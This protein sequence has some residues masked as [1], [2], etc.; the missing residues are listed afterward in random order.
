VLRKPCV[1]VF[2]IV[3]G[4]CK[5]LDIIASF[6][7]ISYLFWFSTSLCRSVLKRGHD[8]PGKWDISIAF[9][10][11]QLKSMI[12]QSIL[13]QLKQMIYVFDVVLS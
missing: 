10:V 13:G 7:G 9:N 8:K 6:T 4:D 11:R 5:R 1:W 2:I 12:S 3:C